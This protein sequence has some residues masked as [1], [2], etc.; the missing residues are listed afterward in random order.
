MPEKNRSLEPKVEEFK[1]AKEGNIPRSIEEFTPEEWARLKE[2][3]IEPDASRE[4]EFFQADA[5]VVHCRSIPE[6]LELLP[7]TEALEKYDWLSDYWWK[8]VSADKDEYTKATAEDLDDGYFIRVLP[9]YRLVYPVQTCL[10]IRTPG[11]VQKVHNIVIVEEGAE[12]NLITAC[13]THPGVRSSFHIGVSEFYVKRNAKLTFTMIHNWA[14]ETHVR[15]R[16]GVIVE[17]GGTYIS[18]YVTLHQVATIQTMPDCRLVGPGAKATFGSVVAAPKGSYLDLGARV[19]LEAP[20]TRAEI[21]SRSVSYGGESLAR[22]HLI[23]KAPEVKAHLECQGL[24][25]SDEGAI[26]AIPQ[27]DAYYSNVEMSHEAA[28][29]KVAQEEIEYL[30]ARGLSEEEATSL[31]VQGFLNVRI[32]GLPE[33][34]QKRIDKAIELARE[35]L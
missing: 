30:M 31:I 14:D 6:G 35:G 9:G 5:R 33:E 3:G 22:G 2:V 18:T 10:Y 17:E 27:L 23:G 7:V 34:L 13:T 32:E 15:P 8:S 26:K 12:L 29:G 24:M 16:T 21:I 20:E 4:G 11:V 25:L 19:S 1:S 28:V